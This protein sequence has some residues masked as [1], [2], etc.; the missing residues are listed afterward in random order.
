MS[1][2]S[3]YGGPVVLYAVS[4]QEAT[5]SGDRARMQQMAQQAEQHL[6]EVEGA[7]QEL[8]STLGSNS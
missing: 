8:R 1:D 5:Q 2:Q 3:S 7:L 6:K 4:I